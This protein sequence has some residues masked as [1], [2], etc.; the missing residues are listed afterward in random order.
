MGQNLKGSEPMQTHSSIVETAAREALEIENDTI[1]ATRL[2]EDRAN[3]DPAL[4]KA[5]TGPYL[6][7]AAYE[8]VRLRVHAQRRVAWNSTNYDATGRGERVLAHAVHNSLLDFPLPSGMLLRNA[9]ATDVLDGAK[10]YREQAND[11]THKAVW[12]DA[13]A[14]RLGRRT[15]G[16]VFSH[17]ALAQLQHET[18]PDYGRA[19]PTIIATQ[20]K[21]ASSAR[22]APSTP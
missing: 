16:A 11:M 15:V 13:I 19:A 18:V 5:L 14:A 2:L 1:K 6:H 22:P 8:A 21:R 9:K 10:R 20:T 7:Q 4:F 12:L 17:E 3:A